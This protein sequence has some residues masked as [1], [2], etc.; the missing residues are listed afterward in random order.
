MVAAEV[1]AVMVGTHEYTRTDEESGLEETAERKGARSP[2]PRSRLC[3]ALYIPIASL[4]QKTYRG[5]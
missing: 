2:R 5:A 1:A 4:C 3:T